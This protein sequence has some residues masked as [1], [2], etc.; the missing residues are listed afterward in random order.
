VT[1]P[2]YLDTAAEFLASTTLSN[3]S[4]EALDR[5]RRIFAD[6]I[7]V[8]AAGMQV[9][10][11]KAFVASQL[12]VAAPGDAWVLGT[13]KRASAL[14][15]G[16]LNGTAGT[17]L[18]LDEG[19]LFAKGHPG[20]QV[21][22]A[23][24]AAAQT[25]G[26]SGADL[27]AAVTLG[28]EISSRISRASNVRLTIHPH[29][30]Y[31]VIGAA[32]AVGKLKRFD[33]AR[34]RELLNVASTMGMATSR[35]T[36]LEGATVRNIYTGH[37]AYMGLTAA[38][39]VECG[40]TGGADCVGWIFGKVLSDTFSPERVVEGLGKEWLIAKSY[41]KLHCTGRYI[42]SA[43]DALEDALTRAPGGRIDP[44][45][46]ERID[47]AAYS[48][49]ASLAGKQ[50]TTSF[51]ARFSVPFALATILHHGRSDTAGFE[52]AAVANPAVQALVAKVFVRHEPG[53]DAAFPDRQLVDVVIRLK[54][55]SSLTG[56]CEV[57]KGEPA[58]PHTPADLEGKFVR[59]GA[60]IW[61]EAVTRKLYDG[62]MQLEKIPD[63]RAFASGFSL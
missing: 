2:S 18:E 30:T 62:C 21:V 16:L 33:A 42:H 58:N 22:P 60:P 20:I 53:Y 26:A 38:R 24:I 55:G 45:A 8:V 4:P 51:G 6:C 11:M 14:D 7:P 56:R 32:V 48:L 39:L 36:L 29:G 43:I 57:T 10:E 9:P 63:F 52:E 15:A 37:S 61:G 3:I 31:G 19:N 59:L 49:A 13:G 41:F 1:S 40:F 54:D 34:M 28:Y 44:L 50:I 27:L 23:A 5:G 17:W 35:N 12:A 46:V 25:S 47:V